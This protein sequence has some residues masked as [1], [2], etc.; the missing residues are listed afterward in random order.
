MKSTPVL[1]LI[2]FGLSLTGLKTPGIEDVQARPWEK[3]PPNKPLPT[4]LLADWPERGRGARVR[5]VDPLTLADLPGYA[6]L[7][8]KN[9][10][11]HAFSPGGRMLA[12][13]TSDNSSSRLH[14]IDLKTWTDTLINVQLPSFTSGLRFGLE[15]NTLYWFQATLKSYNMPNGSGSYTLYGDYVLY[16]YDIA[17]GEGRTMTKFPTLF[18]PWPD[19]ALWLPEDNHL[20]VYGI[21]RD[22]A[23][24]IRLALPYV[25]V[26]NLTTGD[27]IYDIAL[28]GVELSE[29]T[30]P[31]HQRHRPGW[32]WDRAGRRLYLIHAIT[33]RVTV[34]DLTQGKVLQQTE[35][36]PRF[37]LLDYLWH[38]LVVPAEAKLESGTDRY[39]I[40]SP[41][42]AW[43]YTVGM[44]REFSQQAGGAWVYREIPLKFQVI[45]T[46]D[47]TE[48][49]RLDLPV[50]YINLSPDGR[51]LLLS[52]HTEDTAHTVNRV[53]SGLYL[54]DAHRIEQ[55]AHLQPGTEFWVQGFTP[56]S[57]YAY[58]SYFDEEG[59][60]R[61]QVLD[62][63]SQR[64]VGEKVGDF[65]SL[66]VNTAAFPRVS[67]IRPPAWEYRAPDS[68][69]VGTTVRLAATVQPP[70]FEVNTEITNVTANLSALG[71]PSDL[72]LT[73]MGD[74]TYR[75]ETSILVDSP[76][77]WRSVSILIEQ[78]TPQGP[79]WTSF[80]KNIAVFPSGD[81]PIF[82][83][84]LFENWG[85]A[86]GRGVEGLNLAESGIVYT[87]NRSSTFQVKGSFS[88]WTLAFQAA[89]PV[90]LM[91][92]NAL[93]FAFHPGN[94]VLPS[95]LRSSPRLSIQLLPGKTVNLLD[96]KWVDMGINDW[97]VVEIPLEVF[98][99]KE[100]I[101]S[102]NF[103]G[104]LGGTFYL[105]DIRLT[106]ITPSPATAVLEEHTALPQI[107][108]LEQNYPNPFNSSTAIRFA[109]PERSEV[110][111]AV[112]NLM[113]QKVTTL[114]EGV[115]EAGVYT[116]R[117][118]GQD[119]H[120]QGLASGMYLYR[121]QAGKQVETRKLLLLR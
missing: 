117:W 92:Y 48:I 73:D 119:G 2:A 85:M 61:L 75:L 9:Y 62:L 40:L 17:T 24:P 56:D 71:G 47:L 39:A 21:L 41:D 104:N 78:T 37:S 46:N 72:P 113:G 100:P 28:E 98:D 67:I 11:I 103:S 1:F 82:D 13:V 16:R 50:Q 97:Q 49:A 81:L 26:I 83:E 36:H 30:E 33:D 89:V 18:D 14:L 4:L 99:L 116:V 19:R 35:V 53:G 112:Y 38:Q 60:Y 79:Y 15:G 10:Y 27:I 44:R 59:V 74:G 58:V 69:V 7:D 22:S 29:D 96:G 94:I 95:S 66:M 105:D 64:A 88:G 70:L 12:A 91:G 43:L 86:V 114:V 63:A 101:R 121:L 80:V 25:Y 55:Q 115:R 65:G 20:A 109:L 118:D 8:F 76:T 87:G 32:D 5:P 42:G 107:F 6:S 93:R 106:A 45:D 110:E 31:F 54:Y 3:T 34:V 57:R 77:G 84:A 108:T 120:G 52:G 23:D 111:L 102:V 68:V 51:W 90:S